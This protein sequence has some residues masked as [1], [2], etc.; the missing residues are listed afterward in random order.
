MLNQRT[1]PAFIKLK[2]MIQKVNWVKSIVINGQ[3]LTGL[4]QIIIMKFLIGELQR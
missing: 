2:N 3:L 1:N 4:E